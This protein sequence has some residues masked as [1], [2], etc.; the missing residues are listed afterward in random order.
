MS[1]AS[2]REKASCESYVAQESDLDGDYWKQPSGARMSTSP[3]PEVKKRRAVRKKRNKSSPKRGR[4]RGGVKR[5][6]STEVS[7]VDVPTTDES[8]LVLTQLQQR[9]GQ[10]TPDFVN[11]ITGAVQSALQDHQGGS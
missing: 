1:V 7:D 5:D 2:N 4:S 3:E 8:A 6:R 9:T 10:K 11:A